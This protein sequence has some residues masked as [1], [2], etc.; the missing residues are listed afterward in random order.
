MSQK[1]IVHLLSSFALARYASAPCLLVSEMFSL[2]THFSFEG[3]L[4]RKTGVYRLALT[5]KAFS[6]SAL[7][8]LWREIDGVLDLIHL[9]PEDVWYNDEG[10]SE[11]I[12][13]GPGDN[14]IRLESFLRPRSACQEI[15]FLF[16][17][18]QGF[19][20]TCTLKN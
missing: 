2:I 9:L 18:S 20:S 16:V 1:F 4:H 14:R 10:N 5:C 12:L 19:A 17:F 11:A 8:A 7:D 13:Y 3:A 15:D 6:E